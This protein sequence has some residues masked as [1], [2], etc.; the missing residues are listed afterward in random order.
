MSDITV[1]LQLMD[2]PVS[3]TDV[4]TIAAEFLTSWEELSPFLGLT[5]QHETDIRKDFQEHSSQKRQALLK[6]KKIKGKSATYRAF[7]AA[8]TAASNEELGDKVK[9]MLQMRE[10]PTG[11]AT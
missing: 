9:A 7:I 11:K 4:T 3:D 6:W 2:T 1:D 8:A 5:K 10:T